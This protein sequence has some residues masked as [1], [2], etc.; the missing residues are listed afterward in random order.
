MALLACTYRRKQKADICRNTCLL[1]LRFQMPLL[2]SRSRRRKVVA[3][4]AQRLLYVGN[5]LAANAG[6]F[7]HF[8]FAVG[9]KAS[10]KL[11][12]GVDAVLGQQCDIALA[13]FEFGQ[14][15]V[16]WSAR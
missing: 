12:S 10:D 2:G 4:R 9:F 16:G 11:A 13:Y 6:D 3:A 7:E 5:D 1:E 8:F 15:Q 14:R